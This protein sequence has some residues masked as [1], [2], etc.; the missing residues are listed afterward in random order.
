MQHI[1]GRQQ[2]KPQRE[3]AQVSRMVPPPHPMPLDC[4]WGRGGAV[5]IASMQAVALNR[6]G[7]T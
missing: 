2:H 3:S 1:L 6:E 4:S 5:A 7:R